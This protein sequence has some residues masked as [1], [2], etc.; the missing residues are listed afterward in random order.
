MTHGA[1]RDKKLAYS[2]RICKR[3]R[4]TNFAVHF[5]SSFPALW[6]RVFLVP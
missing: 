6:E 1:R 5:S 3:N 4:S 2:V